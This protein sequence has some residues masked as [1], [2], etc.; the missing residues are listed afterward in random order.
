MLIFDSYN[1][2]TRDNHY[3]ISLLWYHGTVNV[4]LSIFQ[5][6]PAEKL[7]FQSLRCRPDWLDFRSQRRLN[8]VGGCC[9]CSYCCCIFGFICFIINITSDCVGISLCLFVDVKLWLLVWLGPG[10]PR[11]SLVWLVSS[12][13]RVDGNVLRDRRTSHG[14]DGQG[15][16]WSSSQHLEIRRDYSLLG[17]VY[18]H[19]D[20]QG[21]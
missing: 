15:Q 5:C 20:L 11:T 7:P 18:L 14:V 10:G 4:N 2:I 21:Q 9:S 13:E 1:D 17:R 3:H 8:V 16:V 6:L 19:T 12:G